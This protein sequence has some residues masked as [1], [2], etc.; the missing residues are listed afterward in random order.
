MKSLTNLVIVLLFI[1]SNF[2]SSTCTDW[3]A[4]F[5]PNKTMME[6]DGTEEVRLVLSNLSDETIDTINSNFV[7]LTTNE[8][9]A[10]VDNPDEIEFVSLTGESGSWEAHLRVRGVFLG[11]LFY[12]T[13]KRDFNFLL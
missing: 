3:N 11:K 7:I 10:V 4:F 12:R 8:Q 1:S 5:D 2:R 9:V 6:I 13:F